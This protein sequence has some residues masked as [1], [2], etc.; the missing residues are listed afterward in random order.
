MSEI[1]E[2]ETQSRAEMDGAREEGARLGG[3]AVVAKYGRE[4]MAELGRK[5][6][7]ALVR[8]YGLRFYSEI[9][10]RNRGVKKRPRTAEESA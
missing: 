2:A 1:T 9:A 7:R 5:G 3:K 10:A 8:K 4:H 6:S